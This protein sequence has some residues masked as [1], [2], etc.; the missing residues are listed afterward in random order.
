[1]YKKYNRS[2]VVFLVLYVEDIILFEN[3]VGV[4]LS[5][6]IW[7][8]NKFDMKDL[9]ESAIFLGSNSFEIARIGC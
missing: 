1:V 4:L 9:G 5:V 6:K 8:S 7:L 3:N 2:V